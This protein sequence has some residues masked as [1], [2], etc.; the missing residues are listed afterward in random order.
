MKNAL[1][2]TFSG[3]LTLLSGAAVADETTMFTGG[4]DP[5]ALQNVQSQLCTLNEGKSMAQYEKMFD[6]YIAW[7]KV[8]DV[9][10]TVVR[11]MPLI[12]HDNPDS[13]S[14]MQFVEHLVSDHATSGK[15]WDLWVSTPEGQKLNEE[16]QSIARCDLK[17]ST[18]RTQWADVEALNAS[19]S[20]FA[21]W[22]WCTR[23]E[24]VSV[25]SLRSKHASIAESYPEGVGNI[26]WFT[27]IPNI[28]GA[29]APGR[30]ANIVVFP[31]MTGL[32]E[33]KQWMANGGWRVRQDYYNYVDCQGD[34][35]W[36]E[37]VIH[38][39]GE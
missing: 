13:R 5:N 2:I 36:T 3:A 16:W 31:T 28:G 29:K 32:M 27:F 37:E 19:D 34:Y 14:N 25:E 8:N 9:E 35:V 30:F 11:T 24:G 7:S 4:M 38:R 26:G 6:K 10:V 15:A 21:M 23:K 1:I 39:P 17:M 33:H 18:L 20:R 22:N 12:T